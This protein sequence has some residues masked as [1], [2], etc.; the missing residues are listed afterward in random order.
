MSRPPQ[1]MASLKRPHDALSSGRNTLTAAILVP[2][3]PHRAVPTQFSGK[4]GGRD[5]GDSRARPRSKGGPTGVL[6]E[7][8]DAVGRPTGEKSGILRLGRVKEGEKRC[9]NSTRQASRRLLEWNPGGLDPLKPQTPICASECETR[10]S[11]TGCSLR[12]VRSSPL[13]AYCPP[14]ATRIALPLFCRPSRS[15]QGTSRA[16]ITRSIARCW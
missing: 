6:G 9:A 1:K 14:L 10:L 5:V 15:I 13:A 8:V 3:S 7:W 12:W 16:S 4:P 2:G 11:Q